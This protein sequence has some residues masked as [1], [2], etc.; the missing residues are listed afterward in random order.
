[1]S[2]YNKPSFYGV[3]P[4]HIRYNK[5]L[6][7][8]ARLVYSEISALCNKNGFCN[9]KNSTI[10]SNFDIDQRSVSRYISQMADLNLIWISSVTTPI[11]TMRRIF[12]E[13]NIY[14]QIGGG[15]TKLSIP[16]RQ[17]CRTE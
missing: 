14:D 2:E 1:M 10:A 3:L 11:G 17:N 16:P 15:V 8:M 5:N 7:P 6:P 13:K 12:V 9:A 4:A